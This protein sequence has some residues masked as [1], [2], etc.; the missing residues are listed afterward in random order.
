VLNGFN[1]RNPHSPVWTLAEESVPYPR[2]RILVAL[3]SSFKAGN[4]TV[5]SY[6]E[7]AHALRPHEIIFLNPID[8]IPH[9]PVPK[10]KNLLYVPWFLPLALGSKMRR[11][12]QPI[13]DLI[14]KIKPDAIHLA[15]EGSVGL[16]LREAARNLKLPYTSAYHTN[17]PEIAHKHLWLPIKAGQRYIADFHKPSQAIFV[18]NNS[19][20][21]K[22]AAL[23][24]P[25]EKMMIWQGTVKPEFR[26]NH[27]IPKGKIGKTQHKG[28][29]LLY[30]GRV[31]IK[32]KNLKAFLD[33]SVNSAY[34]KVIVGDGRDL[35]KLKK[36]YPHVVFIDPIENNE[37]LAEIINSADCL[38]FPSINDTHGRVIAEA[39]CCGTPV[40]A[41][42]VDGP[43]DFAEQNS[44]NEAIHLA[45][46]TNNPAR[47]SKA[48]GT[49]VEAALN[50]DNKRKHIADAAR[51]HYGI[52]EGLRVFMN[53]LAQL[54]WPKVK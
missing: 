48:L 45:P 1:I 40:A 54:T 49:A 37:L 20:A 31:D 5:A 29:L 14:R 16:A 38:V 18:R 4:G 12:L 47:D 51:K 23:G 39:L 11:A 24:V 53:N 26:V 41:F 21:A 43:R 44:I 6:T 30:I 35:T 28:K 36:K 34:T 46:H 10:F 33:L 13:E 22:L 25:A 50:S 2:K 19:S 27:E 17:S 52:D 9:L 3:D 32:E 8:F 42:R 7:L 15:T